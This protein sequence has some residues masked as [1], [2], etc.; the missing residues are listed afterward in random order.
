[1]KLLPLEISSLSF[2]HPS[3][4]NNDGTITIQAEGGLTP[5]EYSIDGGETWQVTGEF[6]GLPQGT[7][8]IVVKDAEDTEVSGMEVELKAPQYYSD[9]IE[10]T[11]TETELEAVLEEDEVL[12]G[13][14]SGDI[15]LTS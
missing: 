3:L 11:L 1:M 2:T 13:S 6:T 5:Y 7:Y 8:Q 15:T 12:E 14:I 10:A 4:G 9:F